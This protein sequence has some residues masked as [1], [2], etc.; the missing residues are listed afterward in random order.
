MIATGIQRNR[1]CCRIRIVVTNLYATTGSSTKASFLTESGGCNLVMIKI[2]VHQSNT[3]R[4]FTQIQSTSWHDTTPHQIRKRAIG[5]ERVGLVAEVVEDLHESL[6]EGCGLQPNRPLPAQ[7]SIPGQAQQGIVLCGGP[8]QITR[9]RDRGQGVVLART[10][11][12]PEP[13]QDNVDGE[14]GGAGFAQQRLRVAQ[15]RRFKSPMPRPMIIRRRLQI[16][17]QRRRQR[18][19]GRRVSEPMFEFALKIAPCQP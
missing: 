11:A 8:D 19:V 1:E 10:G 3:A 5:A 17:Y 12:R 9:L 7:Q 2:S 4:W 6:L 16:R 15:S 13:R 18:S 14:V